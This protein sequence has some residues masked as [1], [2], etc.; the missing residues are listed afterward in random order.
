L[1]RGNPG[2]VKVVAVVTAAVAAP[3]ARYDRAV[4][5]RVYSDR[6]EAGRLLGTVVRERIGAAAPNIVLGLPRGGVPVAAEVA[7]AL[8]AP[9][10]VLVV[11]KV[12]VPEQPELAMGAVGPGGVIVRNEDLLKLLQHAAREFERVAQRE[13]VEVE[14]REHAYR[15]DRPPLSLAGRTAILVD[16][17]IATGA[18]M[19][20]GV[21]A[22]RALGAAWV[23]VATPVAASEAT[24]LLEAEADEVICLQV[25]PDF[26]AVGAWY[27]DFPQLDDDEVRAL[28]GAA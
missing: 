17:G 25:P 20:A 28:L 23:V 6:A 12:G 7:R 18:T 5:Y 19:R 14:R 8:D 16:D 3:A 13:R 24:A 2:N 1:R 11:R 10:D 9:L 22:A 26:R 4:R 15:G 27:E 21:A